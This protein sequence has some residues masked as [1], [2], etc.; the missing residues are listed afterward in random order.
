MLERL[1]GELLEVLIDHRGK[2]PKKLG[3]DFVPTGIPVASAI[4]VKSGRLVFEG[5]PRCVTPEIFKRWMP[6]RLKA[7]DVLLTSEAPLGEVARVTSNEPLVLGQRLFG[8]RGRSDVLDSGY[9]YYA[10]QWKPIQDR[11]HARATGTTVHGIRQSE[12]VRVTVPVPS[13][14]QQ[15]GIA[16][17]LGALDA[18][19]DANTA[20][21]RVSRHLGLALFDQAL[22]RAG[23]NVT[24]GDLAKSLTRGVAPKY[25]DPGLGVPVLNQKCI[26]DGWASVEAARWMQDVP[27]SDAKKAQRHDVVVNSTGVGTLGRVARWL[28]R[29]SIAVDGHVTVVRPDAERYSPVVFG[30]AMLATQLNIEALGEGSTGQTELSRGRLAGLRIGVPSGS[31]ASR[32]AT[33]LEMLDDH[34]ESLLRESRVLATLRNTLLPW[35][36]SGELRVREAEELVGEAV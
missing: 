14:A 5:A 12:L 22:E 20:T 9:L 3:G 6:E 18:K 25:T 29:E 1:L 27:V 17:V 10:L 8:L 4:N 33:S 23:R 36:L 15:R 24:V 31:E 21:R 26:R 11:L 30:Y 32:I 34:A 19:I 13:L 16:E 2:T 28:G 7:G 35:L